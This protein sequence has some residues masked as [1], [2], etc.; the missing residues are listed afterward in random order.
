ME[1]VEN[2][3][4][5]IRG[6]YTLCRD[7]GVAEP[8]IAVS[9]NWFTVIFPRPQR[10]GDKTQIDAKGQVRGQEGQVALQ[11]WEVAILEMCASQVR[12]AHNFWNRLVL[13]GERGFLDVGWKSF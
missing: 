9:D 11:K 2:I 1:A 10:E 4:S 8:K 13:P 3:G 6:I 5:G 7:Y 12:Q